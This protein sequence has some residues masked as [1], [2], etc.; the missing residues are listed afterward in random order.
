[1]PRKK[2]WRRF[3]AMRKLNETFKPEKSLQQRRPKRWTI[4]FTLFH[5]DTDGVTQASDSIYDRCWFPPNISDSFA[6]I[7]IE[8][9]KVVAE[10]GLPCRIGMREEEARP[11]K[12]TLSVSA[13]V[14]TALAGEM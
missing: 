1:M 2:S 5:T 14:K 13:A 9:D 10:I 8:Q 6:F 7:Q 12:L 11:L 4:F 3:S